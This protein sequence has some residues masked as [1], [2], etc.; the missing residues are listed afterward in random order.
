MRKLRAEN[1][2]L[3]D[4][5]VRL[6]RHLQQTSSKRWEDNE[7]EGIPSRTGE[8]WDRGRGDRYSSAERG[9]ESGRGGRDD[10]TSRSLQIR[11]QSSRRAADDG[12]PYR[13]ATTVKF[14]LTGK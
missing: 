6:T 11:S 7:R 10:V 2:Q 12:V 5:N 4:D 13:T 3:L 8:S 14:N 9:A 1:R